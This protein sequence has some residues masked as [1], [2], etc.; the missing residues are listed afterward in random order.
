[1]EE[2]HPLAVA[3]ASGYVALGQHARLGCFGCGHGGFRGFAGKR[4]REK[5]FHVA[6]GRGLF[7]GVVRWAWSAGLACLVVACSV[8]LVEGTQARIADHEVWV[9]A[10]QPV[11]SIN[12]LPT[13]DGSA[14]MIDW[15]PGDYEAI[16]WINAHI[17]GT[18]VMLEEACG[19][20]MWYSQ[21]SSYTG[22]PTV[23]GWDDHESEQRP[24]DEVAVREHDVQTI[25]ATTD[26][27]QALALIHKYDVQYVYLGQLERATCGSFGLVPG[28]PLPEAAVA[29]FDAMVGSALQV[30]YR[31]PDVTI[32]KVI[33]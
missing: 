4:V 1:M 12:Y 19:P 21:V 32:Y 20:W 14:F 25:Y 28:K 6:G 29:K 33:G 3:L 30:V 31:N 23:L 15:F 7:P 10:Q 16:Q 13:L 27:N 18:P 9:Q 17:S 2:R 22:L 8:F 26:P 11:N 24:G 5:V